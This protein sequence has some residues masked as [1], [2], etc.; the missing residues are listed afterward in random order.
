MVAGVAQVGKTV[1]LLSWIVRTGMFLFLSLVIV[2]PGEFFFLP[3][4]SL[5]IP[6]S[7][8]PSGNKVSSS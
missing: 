7:L 1:S 2:I 4:R 8:N 3:I 5:V 6:S